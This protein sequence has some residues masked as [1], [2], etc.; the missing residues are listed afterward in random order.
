SDVV[1]VEAEKAKNV[2]ETGK[3]QL[4]PELTAAVAAEDSGDYAKAK[5][6]Y[7]A[8]GRIGDFATWTDVTSGI[9]FNAAMDDASKLTGPRERFAAIEA[10]RTTIGDMPERRKARTEAIA[11]VRAAAVREWLVEAEK[12]EA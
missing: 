9:A 6:E 5:S 1:N 4:A 2:V 10:A 11:K 12:T 3:R 7:E 8:Q